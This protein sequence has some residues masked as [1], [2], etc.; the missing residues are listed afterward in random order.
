MGLKDS[1]VQ[2]TPS[3]RIKLV[4]RDEAGWG[5][6]ASAPFLTDEVV[7]ECPVYVLEPKDSE[8]LEKSKG[9][10][11]HY[12]FAWGQDGREDQCAIAFGFASLYN[13]SSTPNVG[14]SRDPEHKILRFVALRTIRA[15]E[16]LCF[17]YGIPLWFKPPEGEED[18]D[19]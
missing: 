8:A 4:K 10:L 12:L 7:E 19:S 11:V 17:D 5:V 6:F 3:A 2:I 18:H 16:E 13:H 14:L 1:E 15:Q 9:D